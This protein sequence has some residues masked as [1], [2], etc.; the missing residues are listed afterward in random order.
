MSKVANYI[1]GQEEHHR[2]RS[3]AEEYE[4]FVERYGLEWRD[5]GNR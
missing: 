3:F 5:E 1:A 4:I 2:K